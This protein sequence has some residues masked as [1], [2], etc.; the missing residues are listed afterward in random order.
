MVAMSWN[1]PE[2][3][4]TTKEE[5]VGALIRGVEYC[6]RLAIRLAGERRGKPGPD[7]S[8]GLMALTEFPE[9]REW[10]LEDLPGRV[11]GAVEEGLRWA[12]P[13][14][15]FRRTACRDVEFRCTSISSSA[16]RARS[17]A[18]THED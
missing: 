5:M 12:T 2:V 13:I 10:L 15:T 3:A 8:H 14:M 4:G 7:A 18:W 17:G 11:E 16:C 1:D 6:H 9:Q